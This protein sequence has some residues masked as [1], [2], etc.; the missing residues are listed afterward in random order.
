M[1]EE[2]YLQILLSLSELDRN[3]KKIIMTK[4]KEKYL[5]RE[6]DG[7]MITNIQINNFNNLPL[8]NNLEINILAN[9]TYKIYKPDDI[10]NGEFF[11][12]DRDDRVFVLSYD[13][14]CE[15]LNVDFNKIKDKNNADVR[16]THK[17][18]TNGCIY[19]LAQGEVINCFFEILA[20][21]LL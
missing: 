3:I 1:E 20:L 2:R 4:L 6:I 17:K 11:S 13:I 10:I 16:L 21:Y 15:I 8:S 5:Y 19:F 14:I 7:E 18:T 9:V 12:N